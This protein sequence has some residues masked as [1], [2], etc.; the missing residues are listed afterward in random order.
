MQTQDKKI[1]HILGGSENQLEIILAAKALGYSVLVS[2]MYENPPA[3]ELADFF[4]QANTTDKEKTLE[5]AE[6]YKISAICTDQTDVAVSTVAY[7][8]EKLNLKGIGYEIAQRFTNKRIMRS[9]LHENLSSDYQ[10][11]IPK[12]KFF[13]SPES[14]IQ[15]LS[16]LFDEFSNDTLIVKPINSQGSKGVNKLKVKEDKASQEEKIKLAFSESKNSGILIEDFIDGYEVAVESFIKDGEIYPLCI[17]KKYHYKSNACL[18]QKVE[19]LGDIDPI[20]EKKLFELNSE[21]IR[22][23][24]Q[25]F[26]LNHSEYRVMNGE[27]YLIETAARGAGSNVSGKIVPFLTG[28]DTNIALLKLLFSEECKINISDYKK[29]FALLEF[30]NIDSPSPITIKE[31]SIDPEIYN[32]CE[33]LRINASIGDRIEGASDSRSRIGQ[34]IILSNE[35]VEDLKNKSEKI[36]NL[37]QVKYE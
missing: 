19:F 34:V 17:S 37:I 24:G 6:R 16:S 29:S 8:A 32:L 18:D 26:G 27:A 30:F 23:L 22:T 1:V 11:N 28:F 31:I 21:I 35:S 5:I 4:E 7:I 36:N 25:N 33:E 10:A 20:L 13:E 3:K 12:F 15:G 14:A 9:F 2:D